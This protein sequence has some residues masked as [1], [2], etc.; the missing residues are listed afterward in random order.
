MNRFGIMGADKRM[1]EL[2]KALK[3]DGYR[4]QMIGKES[5]FDEYDVIVLSPGCDFKS[6][7]QKCEGKTVFAPFSE[8]GVINYL[9]NPTF[10]KLNGIP[11]AEGAIYKLMS[12]MEKTV[13]ESEIAIVGFGHIG[14]ELYSMLTGLGAYVSIFARG[15]KK[16]TRPIEQLHSRNFDAIFNTVP[17]KVLTY[18]ILCSFPCKPI[19]IDLASRPGGVDFEGAESLGITCVHELGIPGKYAPVT[20][21][22]VLENTVISILRGA[23]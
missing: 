3:K 23:K 21:G 16:G 6:I 22:W 5:S 19:I 4:A 12:M 1:N 14:K 17:A 8:K 11:S 10:K 7:Q 15:D 20:A 9:E 2:C 13:R 18:D